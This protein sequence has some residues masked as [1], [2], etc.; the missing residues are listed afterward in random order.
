MG[1]WLDELNPDERQGWDDFVD[2]FR[3]DALQKLD[4]SAFVASLLPRGDFDVK[5]AVET[6]AAIMLDKPIL[7][8]AQPDAHVP[9][10]LLAVADEVV[11]VDIDTEVGRREV[12]DAIARM[13]R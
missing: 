2:H 9:R 10:K 7:L 13:A 8:I 5:F 11:Y 4:E 12:A 1:D 3:R 6:G